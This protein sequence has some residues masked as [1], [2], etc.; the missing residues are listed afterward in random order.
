MNRIATG[1]ITSFRL[2]DRATSRKCQI[3]PLGGSSASPDSVPYSTNSVLNLAVFP[4]F[5]GDGQSSFTHHSQILL[6]ALDLTGG[7]ISR[8]GFKAILVERQDRHDALGTL[9]PGMVAC[10][11]VQV[12]SRSSKCV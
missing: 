10:P 3:D 11:I 1:R 6:N 2:P 5:F 4:D 7:F 8:P 12:Q 9:P